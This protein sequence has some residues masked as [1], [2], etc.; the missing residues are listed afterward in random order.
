MMKESVAHHVYPCMRNFFISLAL[1]L[2][3]FGAAGLNSAHA[4]G[5]DLNRGPLNV[6]RREDLFC[7][8][9]WSFPVLIWGERPVHVCMVR[10]RRQGIF[11][12][13]F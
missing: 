11:G 9:G 3:A 2:A 13:T 7:G 10:V 4:Q 1:A 6:F 12:G 5:A 8:R